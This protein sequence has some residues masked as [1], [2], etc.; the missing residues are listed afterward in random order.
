[1]N[2]GHPGAV[3]P[4]FS[5]PTP[6]DL[7]PPKSPVQQFIETVKAK[8]V[9]YL[10]GLGGVVVILIVAIILASGGKE[11]P[12]EKPAEDT[13]ETQ[14]TKE[15]VVAAKPGTLT[16]ELTP[17]DAKVTVDGK[18]IVGASPR[19]VPN[20]ESDKP[21]KLVVSKGDTFLPF[22]QDVNIPAGGNLP[23]PVKLQLKEVTVAVKTEPKGAKVALVKGDEVT[24]QKKSSFKITREAGAD[25]KIEATKKGY[26]T[27]RVPITFTG[28]AAQEVKVVLIKEGEGGDETGEEATPATDKP[29]KT[30]TQ[31]KAKKTATLKIGAVPPA[32]VYVDG[33]K[34]SK[35]TPVVVKVTPG[36]HKVKFKWSNG[37]S[38][39]QK[40][41]VKDKQEKIV[42]GKP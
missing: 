38:N 42:R 8:P 23:L 26:E 18:D 17:A 28:E 20:L 25:Y 11:K 21:H 36:T 27:T 19:V 30:N 33:R 29:K 1:M 12:E 39:T 24:P 16:L 3:A 35:K 6:A 31:P 14:D 41:T 34:Q 40:V 4:A 37:K 9:P 10:A 15:E 32:T 22:E 5:Q 13:K 2:A 7:Q